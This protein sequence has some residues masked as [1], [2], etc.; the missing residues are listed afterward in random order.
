MNFP[1]SVT[2][3][4]TPHSINTNA[5]CVHCNM[6]ST[7]DITEKWERCGSL[8]PCKTYTR[9]GRQTINRKADKIYIEHIGVW[10]HMMQ[11]KRTQHSQTWLQDVFGLFFSYLCVCVCVS[12][13]VYLHCVCVCVWV[14]VYTHVCE[15][16]KAQ[17]WYLESSYPPRWLFYLIHPG[18]VS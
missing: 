16:V 13:Y 5:C 18:R 3:P 6:I 10:R 15:H 17:G 8:G 9:I 2:L 11:K 1:T 7:W 4:F 14:C 12:H